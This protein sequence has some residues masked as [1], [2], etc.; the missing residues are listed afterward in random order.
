MS[1]LKDFR[2][3]LK[4]DKAFS[5]Y[6]FGW[7]EGPLPNQADVVIIGGGVI[8]SS[9]AYFLKR[10]DPRDLKV[11]VVERDPSYTRASTVLSIGGIRQQ[12]SLQENILLSKFSCE[13]L[14]N[15]R[16]YLTVDYEDP[17]D[18][19]FHPQGYLFLAS[20]EGAQ[21]LKENHAVQRECNANIELLSKAKLKERFP[22]LN[23]KDIELGACG[24]GSEG[25][26]DPWTLLDAFKRKA[27]SLGVK[28]IH[29]EVSG[30]KLKQEKLVSS[31]KVNNPEHGSKI[32]YIE[33]SLP[34]SD[35]VIPLSCSTVINAAG[36]NASEIARLVSIGLGPGVLAT[37]LPVEAKKRYVF[38]FHCVNGPDCGSPLVIDRS[39][40][41]FR[42]EGMSGNF[43]AGLS[44]QEDE[45]PSVE[46]LEVDYDWFE[47][48][49]WPTL[50]YR[51]PSF[52]ALKVK[53]AWAGYYDYN[54]VDQNAI[55]G[56]HPIISNFYFAN[57]FSGHGLQHSPAIGRAMSELILDGA[58][59]T[60]DLSRFSFNRFID[61]QPIFE[62]NII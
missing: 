23:T 29:G 60:I 52:E 11:V 38:L 61:N 50:A 55:V 17:P 32:K 26:F 37:P 31:D 48:K 30:F 47:D 7:R 14:H 9:I 34:N 8:G 22:W 18:V 62:R 42:Q 43:L 57:G 49:I 15:V 25:W 51:V 44:P 16:E 46:D 1:F 36:A 56:Q 35:E 10:R 41:Y 5:P 24:V 12:F 13:F 6:D 21:T 28:Y 59:T 58:F 45:E 19:Q 4:T 33:L 39:G 3:G 27:I 20:A 53:S 2:D 54:T 40:T